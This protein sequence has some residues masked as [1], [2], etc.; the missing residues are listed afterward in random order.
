[1][2]VLVT[3]EEV[4]LGAALPPGFTEEVLVVPGLE[5]GRPPTE[6]RRLDEKGVA[7]MGFG[8]TPEVLF[9]EFSLDGPQVLAAISIRKCQVITMVPW[10]SMKQGVPREV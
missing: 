5:G 2:E 10:L 8:V 7:L 4:V 1:M 6:E 3:T 9:E